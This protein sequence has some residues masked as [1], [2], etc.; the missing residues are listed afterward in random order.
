MF[1]AARAC[2]SVAMRAQLW[3]PA[4]AFVKKC[5]EPTVQHRAWRPTRP[6]HGTHKNLFKVFL[7]LHKCVAG[8]GCKAQRAANSPCYWQAV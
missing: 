4:A 3:R 7:E 2:H 5:L 1:N 6:R 8:M